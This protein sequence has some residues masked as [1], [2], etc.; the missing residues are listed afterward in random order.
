MNARFVAERV[1]GTRSGYFEREVVDN[2]RS[3]SLALGIFFIH[4]F[5]V[6][7]KDGRLVAARSGA[8]LHDNRGRLYHLF[9]F[10]IKNL[11]YL[12]E[13]FDLTG[14]DTHFVLMSHAGELG[15]R[16]SRA[17]RLHR[18]FFETLIFLR[19]IR[20]RKVLLQFRRIIH[21]WL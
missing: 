13:D 18:L 14:T 21:T 19:E 16:S 9:F 7:G 1:I 20:G 8:K 2:T 10:F 4:L 17:A 11:L 12:G 5:Q 15:I 3:P 6:M